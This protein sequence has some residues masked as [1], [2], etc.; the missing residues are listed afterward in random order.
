MFTVKKI[1]VLACVYFSLLRAAYPASDVE[2]TGIVIEK[3]S[4]PLALVNGEMVGVGGKVGDIEIV[5]IDKES[6][7]FRQKDR[8]WIKRMDERGVPEFEAPGL[9][10]TPLQVPAEAAAGMYGTEGTISPSEISS[11]TIVLFYDAGAISGYVVFCDAQG[12][13]RAVDVREPAYLE[14]Y[15]LL[16]VKNGRSYYSDKKTRVDIGRIVPSDFKYF[17]IRE[18][19]VILAYIVGPFFYELKRKEKAIVVFNW[20][21]I[22]A[23]GEISDLKK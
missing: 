17:R 2:L 22:Q 4:E 1:M 15:K 14:V 12:R 23:H 3:D 9:D 7:T 18:G 6:V 16:Y 20:G 5:R 21:K 19:D 8:E 13:M 11:L 10:V